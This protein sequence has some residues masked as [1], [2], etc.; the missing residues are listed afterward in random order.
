MK[1]YADRTAFQIFAGKLLMR[2]AWE[3]DEFM[4]GQAAGQ[5]G[6]LASAKRT[7]QERLKYPFNLW[8]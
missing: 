2:G 4:D 8:G 7:L 5:G 6:N 1:I 3:I